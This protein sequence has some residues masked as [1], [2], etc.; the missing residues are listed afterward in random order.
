MLAAARADAAVACWVS[1]DHFEEL[2]RPPGLVHGGFG[3]LSVGNL[4]KPRFWALRALELLGAE[5]AGVEVD[6]D[7]ADSLVQAWAGA[8]PDRVAVAVWNGTLQQHDWAE[9][10]D[11]LRRAVRLELRSLPP[12]RYDVRHRRVDAEHSHLAR[13]AE[14]LGVVDWPDDGQWQALRDLDVLADLPVDPVEVGPE[15]VASLLLD[16][17][18]S[19][20]SLVE[21]TPVGAS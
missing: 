17:P 12:G 19:A 11:D 21:L 20:L 6:G 1:S 14:E 4:A 7:G 2:G 9:R 13:H 16:L 3:L 8:D 15:G 18:T 10:R 5:E